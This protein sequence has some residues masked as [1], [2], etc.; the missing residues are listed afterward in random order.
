MPH[1]INILDHTPSELQTLLDTAAHLKARMKRGERDTPMQGKTLAMYF[2]KPSLR[3]RVSLEVAM[4]SM[5]G[6]AICMEVGS[7]PLGA[8]ESLPDQ[9]RVMSRYV[10]VIS[11]RTF[12]HAAIEEMARWSTVPVINVLSDWSHPTQAMADLLTMREHLGDLTGRTLTYVG[13]GNNVARSLAALCARLGIRFVCSSPEGYT[14]QADFLDTV[15]AACPGARIDLISDPHEAVAE[16]SAVYTDVWASMGQETE[17]EARLAVFRPYQVNA[18]LMQAAPKGAIVLH[19]LPAHRGDEITDEV[20]DSPASAVFDQAE[21]R[22]HINRALLAT[23][24]PHTQDGTA[25]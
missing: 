11:M 12:D 15:R 16:A 19:C 22:M 9:A 20:M 18:A 8:R 10:D 23:L 24:V 7:Q 17:A 5:G 13:D 1:F 14:L 25:A 6:S 21:N 2:Q 4:N 3:T